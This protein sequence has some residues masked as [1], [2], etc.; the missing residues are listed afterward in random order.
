MTSTEA[1]PPVPGFALCASG[2]GLSRQVLLQLRRRNLQPACV[3]LPEFAPAATESQPDLLHVETDHAWRDLIGDLP[4]WYAPAA[5][6]A[7][8]AQRLQ[9]AATDFLLVA[10]WPYRIADSV[11]TAVG[12]AALNLH[13]SLLPA[14]RG[15]DPIGAQLR[16]GATEFGVSLHLLE[17]EFDRGAIVAQKA[18]TLAGN[19]DR[20]AIEARAGQIG[21]SLFARAVD[22]WPR[23]WAPRV[24]AD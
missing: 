11:I 5:R 13:P 10:C 16:D 2:A 22:T 21:T 7:E 4:V 3:V 18:F 8:F 6:Q 14:Y 23:G 1:G 15:I 19:P 17:P 12:K 20:E 24:Q 9:A